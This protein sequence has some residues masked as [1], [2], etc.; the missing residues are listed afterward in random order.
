[1]ATSLYLAVRKINHPA[2]MLLALTLQSGLVAWQSSVKTKQWIQW[3]HG[4]MSLVSEV[5]KGEG[6]HVCNGVS[7]LLAC[8]AI[9]SLFST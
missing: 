5:S 6:F 1:M 3:L 4:C 2:A 9:I 7:I 8:C